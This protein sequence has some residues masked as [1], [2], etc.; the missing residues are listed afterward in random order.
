[1]IQDI[2][3]LNLLL[4]FISKSKVISAKHELSTGAKAAA[5]LAT[6]SSVQYI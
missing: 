2:F 4:N 3:G 6:H 5:T 1:M